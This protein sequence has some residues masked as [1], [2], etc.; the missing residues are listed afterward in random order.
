MKNLL[1]AT[2][3]LGK[4]RE[5]LEILKSIPFELKILRDISFSE[6]IQ[7]TGKTFEENAVLKA[8]TIGEKT[9]LLTLA[10]DS[11][12]AV[13][14]MGGKP[15]VY[16]A[17]FVKGTDEDRVNKV[18]VELKG[19]QKDKRTARFNAVVAIYDPNTK[20]IQTFDGVSKGYIIE[21]PIGTN[22]FGYDPIFFNLE[23]NKT[24]AQASIAEKN[25]VSHR[26]RALIKA[27]E[28][29]LSLE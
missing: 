22:G 20:S 16:S 23:L 28:Y 6:D 19:V 12:L 24:N 21:K 14:A 9:G 1:I 15:G 3:N 25:K 8:K 10:E 7:E 2:N 26:F 29:L 11:G 13:D 27:K 5:F 4:I 17:R 18:L